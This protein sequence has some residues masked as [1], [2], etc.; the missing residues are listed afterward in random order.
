MQKRNAEACQVLEELIRVKP[1][2]IEAYVQRGFLY[3]ADNK[4]DLAVADFKKALELNS[5]T[6]ILPPNL[7]NDLNEIIKAKTR[8]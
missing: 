3:K 8:K 6:N 2:Y 5:K 1:D 4:S 7:V